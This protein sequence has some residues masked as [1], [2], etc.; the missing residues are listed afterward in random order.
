VV[1]RRDGHGWITPVPAAW[2]DGADEQ[3]RDGR[4]SVTPG[5][6]SAIAAACVVDEHEASILPSWAARAEVLD[7]FLDRGDGVEGPRQNEPVDVSPD[8]GELGIRSES[9]V[10]FVA[11]NH[12]DWPPNRW[13]CDRRRL[14]WP[15]TTS[16]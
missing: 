12:E 10:D 7:H 2:I 9:D 11:A 6:I 16:G 8:S 3:H 4:W 1:S 5:R 15:N 14:S 13:C